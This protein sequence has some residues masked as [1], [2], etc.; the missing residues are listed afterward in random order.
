M[1]F[2]LFTDIKI[3]LARPRELTPIEEA[4][5]VNQKLRA[6][7][8][9]R[10]ARLTPGQAY[11]KTSLVMCVCVR[12]THNPNPEILVTRTPCLIYTTG[13]FCQFIA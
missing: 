9:A 2:G 4:S 13:L 12:E 11:Q 8:E 7:Y 10:L 3:V 6:N 5:R 1:V